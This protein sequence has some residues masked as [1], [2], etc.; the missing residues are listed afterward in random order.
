METCGLFFPQNPGLCE[1]KYE[2][3][4]SPPG[5]RRTRLSKDLAFRLAAEQEFLGATL[6]ARRLLDLL[7]SRNVLGR[8]R[9]VRIEQ[10]AY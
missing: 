8:N 6:L 10:V 2:I 3:R 1:R 4:F 5:F 7:S 9:N